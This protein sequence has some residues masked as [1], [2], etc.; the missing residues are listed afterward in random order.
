VT[1]SST[2][3]PRSI[4]TSAGMLARHLEELME[5]VRWVVDHSGMAGVATGVGHGTLAS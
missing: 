3:S 1:S 4:R 2:T 5:T